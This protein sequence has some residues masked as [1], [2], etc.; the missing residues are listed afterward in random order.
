VDAGVAVVAPRAAPPPAPRPVAPALTELN[1]AGLRLAW[2]GEGS[3]LPQIV[4]DGRALTRGPAA[5]YLGAVLPDGS[6]V[7]ATGSEGE[8]EEPRLIRLDGGVT[9]LGESSRRARHPSVSADGRFVVYESGAGA[10]SRLE[11]VDLRDGGVGTVLDE[12]TGLFEPSL[13]PDGE[14]L[15]YVS[16]RDGDSELYRAGLDGG[17]PRRLT[18][19]HLEDLAPRVSPDGKWIAFVSNREGRDRLFLVKPDGRGT[20]PLHDGLPLDGGWDAGA[21]EAAE[22][23]AVWTPDAKRVVFAARAENDFWHLVSVEVDSGRATVLSAGPWD[24]HQPA[25]SPDGR[26]VAFVSTRGGTPE[27]WLLGPDG[28]L[29]QVSDD[30]AADWQPMFLRIPAP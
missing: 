28:G 13:S 18:A 6:G 22:Q 16:S 29:A 2:I 26:Y 15:A 10:L 9:V 25:V 27:V 19:F 11:R 4:V 20:R 12:P 1:A 5:H 21:V 24:D 7:I 23:D 14:W 8:L 30:G 17:R 3:G